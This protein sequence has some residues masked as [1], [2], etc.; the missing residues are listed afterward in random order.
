M[1]DSMENKAGIEVFTYKGWS[2]HMKEDKTEQHWDKLLHIR[3]MEG[4]GSH[5]DPV[6]ISLGANTITVLQ[7]L[8][9]SGYIRKQN[10]LLD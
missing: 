7:R 9:D 10:L 2:Y 5:S 8:A 3:T 1:K 4:D 6:P